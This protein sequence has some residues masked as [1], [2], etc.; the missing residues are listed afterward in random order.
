VGDYGGGIQ[1]YGDRPERLLVRVL[2][3]TIIQ[4]NETS[5]GGGGL[6]V[7]RGVDGEIGGM[8]Q[9]LNNRSDSYGGGVYTYTPG[10]LTVSGDV[11]IA[12]NVCD[13][14]GGGI[15]GYPDGNLT[16]PTDVLKISGN[17]QI[18]GNSTK[19]YVGG[20]IALVNNNTTPTGFDRITIEDNVQ[21]TNNT[22][23]LGGGGG[24]HAYSAHVVI[25]DSVK[26]TG[27]SAV[28][29]PS[30]S[31]SNQ[32]PGGGIMAIGRGELLVLDISGDVEISGN[33]ADS[34]GGGIGVAGTMNLSGNVKITGNRA[35]DR[36]S[37]G[38]YTGSGGGI[39]ISSVTTTTVTISENVTITGNIAEAL[40]GGIWSNGGINVVTIA[41]S[42]QIAD[43][44][45]GGVPNNCDG[46]ANGGAL[47]C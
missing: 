41:G 4:D 23:T 47:T 8:A 30:G 37:F 12:G 32:M 19:Y 44:T 27:N 7:D 46:E 39:G 40:G 21:I 25:R 16:A 29:P 14:A 3:H 28:Y 35:N 5:I 10:T 11:R 17:V 26:I 33:T 42:V 1:V 43:N 18:D 20:G 24:I 38:G 13:W 31:L 45:A 36:T 22:A 34:Y 2:D 6:S 15:V 9:I